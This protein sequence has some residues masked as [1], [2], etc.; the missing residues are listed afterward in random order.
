MDILEGPKIT[1]KNF[2]EYINQLENFDDIENSFI[3]LPNLSTED[4]LKIVEA[5][6]QAIADNNNSTENID[7]VEILLPYYPLD[8]I[9]S[10]YKNHISDT[11]YQ[12]YAAGNN[13]Q[14]SE[15]IGDFER[16]EKS[17]SH[18]RNL[19]KRKLKYN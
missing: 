4:G 11:I 1:D 5:L 17:K 15:N 7:L 16:S 12:K 13:E 2:D 8:Y 18:L 3:P 9:L 19:R 14:K 10:H 6:N